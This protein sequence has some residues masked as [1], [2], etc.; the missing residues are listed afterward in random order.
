MSTKRKI[1]SLLALRVERSFVLF[2][3]GI[4]FMGGLAAGVQSVQ[5]ER[6]AAAKKPGHVLLASARR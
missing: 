3:V 6:L 2:A 1:S 5:A 4:A